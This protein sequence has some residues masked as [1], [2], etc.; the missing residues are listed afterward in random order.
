MLNKK[1]VNKRIKSL[2]QN[3]NNGE[4]IRN[5]VSQWSGIVVPMSVNTC[6]P[7]EREREREPET[8]N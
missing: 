5:S 7:G 1:R 8:E 2:R 4:T 6:C 3:S